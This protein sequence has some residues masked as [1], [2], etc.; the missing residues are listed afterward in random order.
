MCPAF[1]LVEGE[2]SQSRGRHPEYVPQAETQAALQQMI[3]GYW[4]TQIIYVAARL[5]IADLLDDRPRAIDVLAKST[6]T[7]EP[8][9]HR[10]MR[11]LTGLGVFKQAENGEYE[12]TALGCC[13]VTGSPGALR[14]RAILTGEEWYKGWGRLLDTVQTG[15]TAFNRVFGQT[16][17]EYLTANAEVAALFNEAMASP[18]EAAARAVSAAYDF[19]WA[20]VLVDVG[21]G[22]GAFLATIL[23]ANPQARGVLFDR[24][25]VA[26]AAGALLASR[27]VADR[28]EVV[29]GNFFDAVPSG[30]DA[31]ILS[32]IIHD[33]DD[34]RCITILKNCR[35]A[36]ARQ[37]RVLVIEQVIP[38]GNEAS[39]SKLM[40]I[41][42]LAL[43]GGRERREDEYRKLLA[44][45][46]L[47]LTRVIPTGVPRSIIEA[48]P[49]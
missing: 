38:P 36:I 18:T 16:I 45:A 31:Y 33:W 32:W 21:G 17:F 13:L 27:G 28:C 35:R 8:S 22:T 41:H 37:G 48:V 26:T 47:R 40:D 9:L 10:L 23:E 49:T 1:W 15:E 5:G 43:T 11:A 19:S 39:L 7:H 46:D 6:G 4:V 29:A 20:N 34:D 24:Q 12:N 14:A 25:D 44:A 30:G 42:M 3:N 2:M